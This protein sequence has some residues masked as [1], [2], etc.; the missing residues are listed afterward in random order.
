[1]GGRNKKKKK[2]KQG[3]AK[4][5]A[6]VLEGAA[7]VNEELRRVAGEMGLD[8]DEEDIEVPQ[9]KQRMNESDDGAGTAKEAKSY[10]AGT[11]LDKG[12]D[13]IAVL[14]TQKAS[15]NF[16]ASPPSI[17]LLFPGLVTTA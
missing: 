16:H 3:G 11:Q 13:A 14:V 1:M 2:A 6:P 10:G 9:K 5:R 8:F 15:R 17:P 7:A 12:N 4:Q